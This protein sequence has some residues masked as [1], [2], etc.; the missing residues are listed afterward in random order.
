[1]ATNYINRLQAENAE[2]KAELDRIREGITDLRAYLVS[3][4]F[5]KDTTVQTRDVLHR[6][7]EIQI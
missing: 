1:M 4:K 6:I 7:E 2:L 3:D 5:S